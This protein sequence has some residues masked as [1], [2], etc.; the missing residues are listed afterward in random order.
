MEP[1]QVLPLLIKVCLVL[2]PKKEY[3]KLFRT[4]ELDLYYK[5]QFSDIRMNPPFFF[6]G[7]GVS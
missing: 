5:M 1:Q 2:M 7:G 4:P 6:F 3:S